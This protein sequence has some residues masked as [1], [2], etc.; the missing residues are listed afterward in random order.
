M[1]CNPVF[2]IGQT[3][4]IGIHTD[5]PFSGFCKETFQF[6]S[7]PFG[8][9]FTADA[10]ALTVVTPNVIAFIV[11]VIDESR[12]EEAGWFSAEVI[13]VFKAVE[14]ACHGTASVMVHQVSSD[15][16][17]V[18]AQSVGETRAFGVQQQEGGSEGSRIDEND[19]CF[20][21]VCLAVVGIYDLDA[22]GFA[23]SFIVEDPVGEGIRA[24]RQVSGGFCGRKSR[25][26]CAEIPAVRASAIAEVSVLAGGSSREWACQVGHSARDDVS[27][28][29][30]LLYF[31]FQDVFDAVER[32]GLLKDTVREGGNAGGLSADADKSFNIFVPRC[33]ILVPDRPVK[34]QSIFC[35]RFEVVI[36]PSETHAAPEQGSSTE[37]ISTD[38]VVT[39][40]FVVGVLE[41]VD[42][43]VFVFFLDGK[44]PG[45]DLMDILFFRGQG[46]AMWKLPGRLCCRMITGDMLQVTPSFE[47][48]GFQ[49]LFTEFLGG[50]SAGYP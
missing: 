2:G 43:E 39:L 38:P 41:V 42:V 4:T 48:H 49:S 29:E 10:I 25:R 7:D 9:L 23:R 37:D 5:L 15:H 19:F 11:I 13:F 27:F 1:E 16:I 22:D 32:H 8:L 6:C 14:A 47:E 18:I 28:G 44:M 21:F 17:V 31:L 40:S 24:H 36:T 26:L 35:I 34:T 50:P 30:G 33:D 3:F 20:V 46:A 45:L 12:N